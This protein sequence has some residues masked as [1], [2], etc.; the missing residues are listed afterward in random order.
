MN[1]WGA[2]TR[3]C[4]K[5]SVAVLVDTPPLKCTRVIS[6][7]VKYGRETD[8]MNN[9]AKAQK[10]KIMPGMQNERGMTRR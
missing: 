4:V 7:A 1:F 5:D 8:T 2:L 6:R 3:S 10:R 9:S